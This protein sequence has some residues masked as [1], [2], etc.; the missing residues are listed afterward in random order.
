MQSRFPQ[1]IS[2]IL[3][4]SSFS[5][6]EIDSQLA[7]LANGVKELLNTEATNLGLELTDFKV[8]GTM[9]DAATK[10][11]IGKVANITAEAMAANEGG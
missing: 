2:S 9:F 7:A 4:K 11:R 6:Q 8:N 3:A 10:E 1:S 5:Y